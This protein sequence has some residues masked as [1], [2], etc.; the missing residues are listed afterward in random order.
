MKPKILIIDD[1]K[2][3]QK[4]LEIA[5]N[6]N[7]Y[8]AIKALTGEEGLHYAAMHNP[9]LILLDLGLPDMDGTELLN[10]L[11]EWSNIPIIILSSRDSEDTKITLLENGADD[12]VTKPF[13]AGELLA[14]IKAALR[15]IETADNISPI[16]VSDNLVLDI[17]N[18]TI[19]LDNEEL[20]CTP[21]EFEL[22]KLF[23]KH[24]G[25]VLTYNWLL[26]EVWG[27]GYQQEVHYLRIFVKQLREK[28]E[29]NPSRPSR[30]RTETGIGY[31]FIS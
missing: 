18:H 30:I 12:Y 28:I 3:I 2:S 6:A 25:K 21:K 29:P 24:R 11:R 19:F 31:R 15:R 1:E 23:M 13:S 14:R 10:K 22:L 9:S 17:V 20:K 5:L 8:I 7:G 16:I 27:I 4:L 26:K